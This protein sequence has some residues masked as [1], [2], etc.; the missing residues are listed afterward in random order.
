MSAEEEIAKLQNQA[1]VVKCGVMFALAILAL[2]V[3]W[4]VLW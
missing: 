3:L 2:L 4:G 1:N